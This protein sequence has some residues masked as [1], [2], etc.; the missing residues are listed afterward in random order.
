MRAYG[1]GHARSPEPSPS[2][3]A[4]RSPYVGLSLRCLPMIS[5]SD[6]MNTSVQ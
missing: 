1:R 3:H 4:K 6:E 5:P 2:P